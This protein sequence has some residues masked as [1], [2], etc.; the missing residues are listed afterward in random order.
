MGTGG[1][2]EA[3]HWEIQSHYFCTSVTI[4][5]R[6]SDREGVTQAAFHHDAGRPGAIPWAIQINAISTEEPGRLVQRL[7]G[8][9]LGCGGWVLSRSASDTGLINLLFEF[10]RRLCLDIYGVILGAGVDLSRNGHV[11][12]TELCQCALHTAPYRGGEIASIDLEV[13]TC[14]ASDTARSA[15][16]SD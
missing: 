13:Q 2:L 1:P 14:I 15:A 5:R 6:R 11:R 4:R 7:T 10:E 3:A 16:G 12:F 9:I 8:A